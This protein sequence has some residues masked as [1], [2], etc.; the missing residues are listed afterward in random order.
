[1]RE[2]EDIIKTITELKEEIDNI[3]SSAQVE[4]GKRLGMIEYLEEDDKK[5]DTDKDKKI[6]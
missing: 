6:K 1:M 5:K 2:K 4:I 3:K